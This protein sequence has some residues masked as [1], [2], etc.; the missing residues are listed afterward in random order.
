M[1]VISPSGDSAIEVI[2]RKQYTYVSVAF[3]NVSTNKSQ[4]IAVSPTYSDNSVTFTMTGAVK[5]TIKLKKGEFVNIN[6][7]GTDTN[8]QTPDKLMYR[9]R[10][11][12]T[13]QSINQITNQTYSVNKDTYT[14]N[15]SDNDYIII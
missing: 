12:T 9:G 8:G 3:T 5:T 2:P 15:Q 4:T 14:E 10:L 1:N 7:Y 11:F 13:D 6:V